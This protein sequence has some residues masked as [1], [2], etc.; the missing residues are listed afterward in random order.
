MLASSH[1]QTIY[2]IYCQADIFSQKKFTTAHHTLLHSSFEWMFE[3]LKSPERYVV[4]IFCGNWTDDVWSCNMTASDLSAISAK[5]ATSSRGGLTQWKK[6]EPKIFMTESEIK[7]FQWA[8]TAEGG[9]TTTHY[10]ECTTLLTYFCWPL[11]SLLCH[12]WD[13]ASI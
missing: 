6:K 10:W 11:I 5:S 1:V 8:H 3:T 12:F 13:G 2:E 4:A 9:K 7:A